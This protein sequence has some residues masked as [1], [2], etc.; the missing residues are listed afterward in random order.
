MPRQHE[1]TPPSPLGP[2]PLTE[3]PQ[4]LLDL[5]GIQSGGR[6]P[7]HFTEQLL[8]VFEIGYWYQ[9]W[10]KEVVEGP[11][12][13]FTNLATMFQ[14]FTVPDGQVWLVHQVNIRSLASV[15]GTVAQ[16]STEIWTS[17]TSTGLQENLLQNT[18]ISPA[19]ASSRVS[20]SAN[21]APPIVLQPGTGV[22]MGPSVLQ[23]ST[24]PAIIPKMIITRC[25]M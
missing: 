22:W 7:Q 25:G 20:G 21:F 3:R 23:G 4:G 2:A 13:T 5:L 18:V 1:V 15:A 6:Y 24:F 14:I 12:T 11:S 16:L 10:Q 17:A 9:Q 19:S 8:P